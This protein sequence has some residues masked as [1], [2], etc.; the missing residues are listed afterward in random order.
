MPYVEHTVTVN[1]PARAVFDYLADGMNNRHWRNG[2]LVIE[3]TSSADGLGATY[4]QVTN[5]G[6][7]GRPLP[8]DYRVTVFDPPRRLEFL[9]TAGPARPTGVFE[10]TENPD[11]STQVRFALDLKAPGF[12][13]LLA[14]MITRR[15]QREVDA[16]DN[17]KAILER[18][19]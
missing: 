4:R 2:V 3:R 8:E 9:I 12:L 11:Q 15:L 13:K 1:R 14:P 6:P 18:A 17:L 19:P 10:L 7:G 16:L 5:S